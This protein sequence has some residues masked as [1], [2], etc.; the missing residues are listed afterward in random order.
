MINTARQV[1]IGLR[2]A[3]TVTL[4]GGEATLAG[5]QRGRLFIAAT[6]FE[7]AL[8]GSLITTQQKTTSAPTSR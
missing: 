1:G 8:I 6:T 2:T 3:L 4:Y 7:T 5:F